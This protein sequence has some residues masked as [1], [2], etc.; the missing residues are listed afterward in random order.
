M[1]SRKV[2]LVNNE[3]YHV[4]SKSIAGFNIFSRI[5][6]YERMINEIVF[7]NIKN[8]PFKFS[9][10]EKLNERSEALI[11]ELFEQSKKLV[12]IIAYCIMPTHL[13]FI[14]K[15]LTEDGIRKFL[16]LILASYQRTP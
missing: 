6:D 12:D 13:H 10:Y 8:P 11:S 15:Q 14:L 7:Y 3:V 1:S 5:R 9:L 4:F 16:S 2:P